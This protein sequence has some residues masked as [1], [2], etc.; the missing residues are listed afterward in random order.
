MTNSMALSWLLLIPLV[1]SL[2]AFASR[3]FRS[4]TRFAAEAAHLLSVTLVLAFSLWAVR[5]VLLL[6]SIFELSNWLHLDSLGAVFLLIIGVVGFL[7]GIYSIGYTRHDLETGEFDNVRL[8]TYYGLF[9]LFLFTMILVITSNNIIMMWAAV[10]ATTLGSAFLVGIYRHPSSLEAAWK[11]IIICT[12]GVAFGLYGTVLVYSDAFNVMQIPGN[13]ILWT[14]IIKNTQAL[15]PTL[16]KMAFV[17]VLVGFGTKAGLFPMHAWLPDAHSEAPSPVS[18]MLSAVLLNCALFVIF[19]FATISNLVLGVSF[20]QTLFLIFG[21][22]SVAA[23]AFFMYVQRDIK[24]LLAYSS[25]ENI[26]LILLAFGIGGPAGIF[27]GLLQ[28]VNHSLVKSLMFCTS[29]NILIKYRSRNLDQVKGMLQVIPFSSVLMMIG[30]LALVG[31]PPFNIFLSKFFII[32]TGLGAGYLWLMILCLLCL[33]VVF[34]AFF[35]VIVAAL[36][37]AKPDE[38]VKGEANWLTLAPGAVLILLIL[39]LG[40]YIPSP[41]MN[42][43]NGASGMMLTGALSHSLALIT[44]KNILSPLARLIP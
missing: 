37:G 43:L 34:A 5:E 9:N 1:L 10:E 30:A 7:V 27:A 36:F 40:L 24:R 14:E 4:A 11:Y 26:G 29:G 17:F 12:V 2:V 25:M 21:T 19:R 39:M 42:L 41:L 44:M 31:V 22:I 13:A 20:A 28:A 8:S 32:T 23:A 35:R 38:T 15:D 3:W 33:T 16:I 6:G 18:A